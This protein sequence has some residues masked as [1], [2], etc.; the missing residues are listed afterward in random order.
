MISHVQHLYWALFVERE[1]WPSLFSLKASQLRGKKRSGDHTTYNT[2]V[3]ESIHI[4]YPLG[5]LS[6]EPLWVT[7]LLS[8]WHGEEG[9]AVLPPDLFGEVMKAFI[10]GLLWSPWKGL[11]KVVSL[12]FQGSII[13]EC[14]L[15]NYQRLIFRNPVLL[16]TQSR[17]FPER[18]TQFFCSI[19]GFQSCMPLATFIWSWI[20]V[21]YKGAVLV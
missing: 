21:R 7:F 13:P 10:G 16:C 14:H 12:L 4:Y 8:L 1:K 15:K 17:M 2:V 9:A 11:R 5:G 6:G 3:A 19:H 20:P 18:K